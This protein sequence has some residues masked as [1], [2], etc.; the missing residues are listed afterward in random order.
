MQSWIVLLLVIEE[1]R[2]IRAVGVVNL[3]RMLLAWL[4]RLGPEPEAPDQAVSSPEPRP[5]G[6]AA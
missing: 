6:K 2:L 1:A 4:L 5:E 3:P